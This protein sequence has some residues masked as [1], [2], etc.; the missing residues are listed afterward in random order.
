MQQDSIERIRSATFAI[1]RKGYDKREVERFLQK[2]A[3]WLE[4]GGGDQARSDLVKRELERVGERTAG[5]LSQAEDS[6]EQLRAE[7][8]T[9]A[10]S[11][12][13]RA[14]EQSASTRKSADEYASRIR[15]EADKYA[16]KTRGEADTSAKETMARAAQEAR[17]G[18][19]DAQ[20]K[21]QRIIEEGN[22]RR[23][24][25]ESVISDLIRRR[26]G[27]AGEVDRLAS[28]LRAAVNA[29][30][31][32][33]GEEDPYKVPDDLDTGSRPAAQRRA[34]GTG[35]AADASPEPDTDTG[36]SKAAPAEEGA[37]RSK[38]RTPQQRRRRRSGGE[39]VK[40]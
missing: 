19:S 3:D 16:Q 14:R 12:L 26:D 37:K 40:A 28:E 4:A 23:E 24:D 36:T 5:I 6:A 31:P 2:L 35:A 38:P 13:N 32:G 30:T 18:L 10:S 34:A 11:T 20:S 39:Q 27:V 21:A 9:E 17:Q 1:A 8:E 33:P 7:A 22:K 15:G 25:I 29:H